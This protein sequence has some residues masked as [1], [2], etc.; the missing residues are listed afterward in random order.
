MS[1]NYKSNSLALRYTLQTAQ[2]CSDLSLILPVAGRDFSS[3]VHKL[4]DI[5]VG[6]FRFCLRS[7]NIDVYNK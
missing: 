7:I 5:L 2:S 1:N 4:A 6:D 3:N